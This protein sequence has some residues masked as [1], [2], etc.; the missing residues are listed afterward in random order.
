M[1]M[2]TGNDTDGDHG[3]DERREAKNQDDDHDDDDEQED[4]D[5]VDEHG[6]QQKK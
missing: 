2:I 1:L 4:R 6:Q 3:G 5:G